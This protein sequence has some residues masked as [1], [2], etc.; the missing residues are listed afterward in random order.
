M[1]T[2]IISKNINDLYLDTYVT[3]IFKTF[4]MQYFILRGKFIIVYIILLYYINIIL[5]YIILYY[6]VN[7]FIENKY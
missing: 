7:N 4:H 2:N 6:Y 5:Y 3:Y 1:H